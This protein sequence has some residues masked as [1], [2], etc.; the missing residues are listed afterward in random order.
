MTPF[1]HPCIE[2]G[3]RAPAPF[4]EGVSLLRGETGT[5]RCARAQRQ[6]EALQIAQARKP[7]PPPRAPDQGRLL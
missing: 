2:P 6:H 4:G 7:P 5:W 3:C 1:L